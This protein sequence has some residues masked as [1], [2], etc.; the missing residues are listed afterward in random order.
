MTTEQ[1]GWADF[2]ARQQQQPYMQEIMTFVQEQREEGKVIYPPSEQ[3]FAAFDA[4]ALN[5]I[6]VVILGQDP[7]HGE[8]QAHGLCFS[9]LPGNKVPPSLSNMYKELERDVAGFE[10]PS[11]GYLRSWASQ[12]VFLLNTVLT[13]EQGAAHSHAKCGWEQFTDQ[14]IDTINQQCNGVVFLLWGKHAEKKGR[15]IDRQRHHVL[16][17]SHPSPLSVRRGFLGCGH[18]SKANELL[19][20]SG[21]QVI[22]WQLPG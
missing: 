16:T 6:K 8:N 21:R 18:F 14:V 13:V 15:F 2:L 9:V 7:Y 20:Q 5:D 17:S 3:I 11:H 19:T 10:R 4:T 22:D 1:T 12:G